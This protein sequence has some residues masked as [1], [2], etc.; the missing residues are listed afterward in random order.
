MKNSTW[1]GT[2]PY[3]GC[4]IQG[5]HYEGCNRNKVKNIYK[6]YGTSGLGEKDKL[7]EDK[8]KIVYQFICCDGTITKVSVMKLI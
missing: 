3:C 2:C 7:Y 8:E 6:V 1:S 4:P 5:V